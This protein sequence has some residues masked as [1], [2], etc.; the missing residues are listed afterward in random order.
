MRISLLSLNKL[1]VFYFKPSFHELRKLP[2]ATENVFF[3]P[4]PP[5]SL[6]LR[7]R[8]SGLRK[9]LSPLK[10]ASADRGRSEA[11][12]L[13]RRSPFSVLTSASQWRDVPTFFVFFCVLGEHQQSVFKRVI[14]FP[15]WSI[16]LK[17][18]LELFFSSEEAD[19]KSGEG[20]KVSRA[21]KTGKSK[22]SV[23]TFSRK[24]VLLDILSLFTWR[25]TNRE[26]LEDQETIFFAK[27]NREK[28][29][30]KKKPTKNIGFSH[31]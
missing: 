1:S 31:L 29:K 20:Q 26:A 11:R 21:K 3:P 15:F 2:R 28:R 24:S 5:F 8:S 14:L 10:S 13:K 17:E 12:A 30:E 27:D 4:R 25:K 23:R 19:W 16:V 18:N 7:D 6:K 22:K 9:R